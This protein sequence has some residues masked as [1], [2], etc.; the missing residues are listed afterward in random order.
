MSWKWKNFDGK[1][2][3]TIVTKHG[4]GAKITVP[5]QWIGKK[6]RVEL[7]NGITQDLQKVI[8]IIKK[9]WKKQQPNGTKEK[10]K[11]TTMEK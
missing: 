5:K 11:N 9:T 2:I 4:T 6:I 10:N 8:D 3:D 1:H 7:L